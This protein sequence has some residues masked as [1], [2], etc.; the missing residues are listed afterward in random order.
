MLWKEHYVYTLE[1][2]VGL[3]IQKSSKNIINMQMIQTE[4][5][6]PSASSSSSS[7]FQHF[8]GTLQVVE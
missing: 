4:Y 3:K 8:A 2:R 6:K 1:E 7:S 5:E